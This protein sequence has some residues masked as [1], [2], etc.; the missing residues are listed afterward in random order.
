M[1]PRIKTG[2]QQ[3]F[4]IKSILKVSK[5]PHST[6]TINSI[7]TSVPSPTSLIQQQTFPTIPDTGCSGH[8]F[9][10]GTPIS[11]MRPDTPSTSLQVHLP[12]GATI[13]SSHSGNINLPDLPSEATEC[14]IF[15]NL[16]G[17]PGI[18][19]HTVG[20]LGI[21]ACGKSE[22]I[23]NPPKCSEKVCKRVET[24]LEFLKK[25]SRLKKWVFWLY[26]AILG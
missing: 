17:I 12:D 1:A 10:P 14:H 4:K 21:F 16:S 24:C 26:F 6:P 15:P 19:P 23:A 9:K 11:N 22:K 2:A 7:S 5:L 3:T 18:E 8:Y 25:L 13:Q 20:N